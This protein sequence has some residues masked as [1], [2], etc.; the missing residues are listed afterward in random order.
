MDLGSLD[1]IRPISVLGPDAF[2]SLAVASMIYQQ[3]SGAISTES[4]QVFRALDGGR[5]PSSIWRIFPGR[6]HVFMDLGGIEPSHN[7]C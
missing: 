7:R 2:R 3:V 5:I 4:P 1:V 6:C